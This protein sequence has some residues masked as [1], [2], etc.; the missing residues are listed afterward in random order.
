MYDHYEPQPPLIAHGV[1]LHGWQGKDGPCVLFIW[2]QH[3][4]APVDQAVDEECRGR[5][6]VVAA[7]R[8]PDGKLTIYTG[9][10]K[11]WFTATIVVRDGVW[12][13]TVLDVKATA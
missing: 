13:D 4:P 6:D 2:R 9:D 11:E 5:A 8:L 7:S 10:S 12:T 1:V 3:C